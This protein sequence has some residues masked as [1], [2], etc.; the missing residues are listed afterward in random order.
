MI[1][2]VKLGLVGESISGLVSASI[3]A[4]HESAELAKLPFATTD[5]P[6]CAPKASKNFRDLNRGSGMQGSEGSE[7]PASEMHW[8]VTLARRSD[9]SPKVLPAAEI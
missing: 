3:T 5:N 1:L 6:P 4:H 8:P 2:T 9:R 7:V